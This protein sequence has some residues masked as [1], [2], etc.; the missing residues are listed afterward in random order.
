MRLFST[1][2]KELSRSVG[3][4]T[5][6]INNLAA[7]NIWGPGYKVRNSIVDEDGRPVLGEDGTPRNKD[8]F[9]PT[10]LMDL[11]CTCLGRAI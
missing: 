8:F 2:L 5:P 1:V 6:R 3:L 11:P 7:V 9:V 10:T 4:R